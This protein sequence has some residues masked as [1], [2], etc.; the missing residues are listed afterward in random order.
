M[1][2]VAEDYQITP[3]CNLTKDKYPARYTDL[4]DKGDMLVTESA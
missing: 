2:A 3:I 4:P 1:V